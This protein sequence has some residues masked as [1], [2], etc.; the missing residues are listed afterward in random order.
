[1]KEYNNKDCKG[2]A[3]S[4]KQNILLYLTSGWECFQ[5]CGLRR[6]LSFLHKQ[7]LGTRN[8]PWNAFLDRTGFKNLSMSILFFLYSLT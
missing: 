2:G 4:Q 5:Q 8:I 6:V 1:M 3:F 7:G